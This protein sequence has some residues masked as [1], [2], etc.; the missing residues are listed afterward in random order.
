MR[1]DAKP[2]LTSAVGA[3]AYVPGFVGLAIDPAI[4]AAT[5]ELNPDPRSV[6]LGVGDSAAGIHRCLGAVGFLSVRL[7]RI[8]GFD[9]AG[10]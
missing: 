4:D 8:H 9:V 3:A 5:S 10:R 7:A 2:G 1:G 6:R